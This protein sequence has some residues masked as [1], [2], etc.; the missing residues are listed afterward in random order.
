MLLAIPNE[1]D[2]LSY[3]WRPPH[4]DWLDRSLRFY[5]YFLIVQR[6]PCSPE[7]FLTITQMNCSWLI[8]IINQFDV[9]TRTLDLMNRRLANM[10]PSSWKLLDWQSCWWG[11]FW[12]NFKVKD[13]TLNHL[14]D[15]LPIHVPQFWMT[16]LSLSWEM[17]PLFQD[18]KMT[19]FESPFGK[20]LRKIPANVARKTPLSWENGNT[21]TL[22][23]GHP[24][25]KDV[26]T[27]C[28]RSST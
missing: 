13:V 12:G 24:L 17:N 26:N 10:V 2:L 5:Y 15:G 25:E 21:H 19:W 27:T 6:S 1:P 14:P 9:M 20:F 3:Q 23:L 16:P 11:Y 8:T 7:W 22:I 4:W 28:T 18:K